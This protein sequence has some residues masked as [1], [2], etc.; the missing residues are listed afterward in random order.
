MGRN[1]L[2]SLLLA[3][4]ALWSSMASAQHA[5]MIELLGGGAVWGA[6][7][8]GSLTGEETDD[9]LLAGE[10]GDL[11]TISAYG[12]VA[13]F[14]LSGPG[15]NTPLTDASPVYDTIAHTLSETGDYIIRVRLA[16]QSLGTSDPKQ[17]DLVMDL[18]R[19]Q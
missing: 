7:Y 5:V 16:E 18:A 2:S 4:L 12:G 3:T 10:A 17:Y 9:Y 8:P 1:V 19:Q 14:T 6:H 13:V 11:V 15:I